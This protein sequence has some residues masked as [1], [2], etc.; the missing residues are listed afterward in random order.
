MEVQDLLRTAAP[1]MLF[2][3]TV[4][5]T[6]VGYLAKKVLSQLLIQIGELKVSVAA[7]IGRTERLEKDFLEFKAQ[8]PMMYVQKGDYVRHITNIEHKIDGMRLELQRDMATLSG[9]FKSFVEKFHERLSDAK[10]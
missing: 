4:L 5:M 6:I 8:L 10:T 1:F 7:S 3:L 9:D 2:A